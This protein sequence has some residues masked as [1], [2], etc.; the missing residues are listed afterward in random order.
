M[1]KMTPLF[2]I[3]NCGP[4]EGWTVL[5]VEDI[6]A[7]AREAGWSLIGPQEQ[8]KGGIQLREQLVGHPRYRES[9]GPMWG[10]EEN[11]RPVIRYETWAA[12]PR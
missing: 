12:W 3:V 5:D 11:G 8:Y 7:F 1:T 6:E 4:S 9:A 2:R 10:G